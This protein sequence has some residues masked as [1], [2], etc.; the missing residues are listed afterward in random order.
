[1]NQIILTSSEIQDEKTIAAAAEKI[2]LAYAGRPV[3]F[4]EALGKTVETLI[5]AGEKS[6]DQDLVLASA[7]AEGLRTYHAQLA[8]QITSPTVFRETRSLLWGLFGELS[9]FLK[10]LYLLGQFDD[11]ARRMVASYGER[12]SCILIAHVLR[13]RELN[14]VPLGERELF[15]DVGD[16]RSELAGLQ[17]QNAIP[18]IPLALRPALGF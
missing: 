14:A 6:A 1:M 13:S 2:V 18:V 3:V 4:V 8:Q 11:H 15:L 7:L 9:D 17:D 10:G 16:L 5:E 12:A